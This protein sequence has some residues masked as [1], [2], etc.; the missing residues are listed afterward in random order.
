M[1]RSYCSVPRDQLSNLLLWSLTVIKVLKRVHVHVVLH[2]MVLPEVPEP[3]LLVACRRLWWLLPWWPSYQGGHLN[4]CS[5]AV[6]LLC[7]SSAG[8]RCTVLGPQTGHP[9]THLRLVA[10]L[11]AWWI[12]LPSPHQPMELSMPHSS[13]VTVF[14]MIWM[15]EIMLWQPSEDCNGNT[16]HLYCVSWKTH[17][18]S[19]LQLWPETDSYEGA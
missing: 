2:V 7:R 18:A 3:I 8:L 6:T 10:L 13:S 16:E 4:P 11:K 17:P 15:P 5:S 12:C 19:G 1:S 14:P 9:R